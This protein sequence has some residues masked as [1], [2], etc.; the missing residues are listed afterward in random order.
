M[1]KRGGYILDSYRT[2]EI[3]GFKFAHCELRKKI[4]QDVSNPKYILTVRGSGF[5]FDGK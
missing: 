3:N 2:I 1:A 5:M 4:E